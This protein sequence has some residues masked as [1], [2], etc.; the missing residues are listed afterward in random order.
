MISYTSSVFFA[1]LLPKCRWIRYRLKGIFKVIVKMVRLELGVT[2]IVLLQELYPF[3]IGG[4]HG[5]KSQMPLINSITALTF[6]SR[7]R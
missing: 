6:K 1:E 5:E 2:T 4:P 3:A 7:L